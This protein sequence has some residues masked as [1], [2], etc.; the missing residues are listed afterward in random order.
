[1]LPDLGPAQKKGRRQR[2]KGCAQHHTDPQQ[3]RIANGFQIISIPKGLP[4]PEQVK[5]AIG[6][7]RLGKYG[8]QRKKNEHR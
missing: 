4:G 6:D 5:T 2:K 3:K 7:D 8:T 1:M